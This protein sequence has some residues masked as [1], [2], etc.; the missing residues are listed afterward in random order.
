M[1]DWFATQTKINYSAQQ[2]YFEF[3]LQKIVAGDQL[4]KDRV[5]IRDT[6]LRLHDMTFEDDFIDPFEQSTHS[7]SYLN[8]LPKDYREEERGP[9]ISIVW[10]SIE[11]DTDLQV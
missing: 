3:S 8:A 10:H 11:I 7:M 5:V 2:D 9:G 1:L 4:K 6:K